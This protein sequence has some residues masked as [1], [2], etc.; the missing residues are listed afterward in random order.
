MVKKYK[1]SY[2]QKNPSVS[3]SSV[4]GYPEGSYNIQ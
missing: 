3:L 2:Y 1:D 4:V